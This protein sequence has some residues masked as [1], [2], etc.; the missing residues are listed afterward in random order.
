[1]P[2]PI[3]QAAWIVGGSGKMAEDVAVSYIWKL[4]FLMFFILIFMVCLVYPTF[5]YKAP[6]PGST[7]P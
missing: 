4:N 6:P 3:L 1:M 2:P 5:L 7:V